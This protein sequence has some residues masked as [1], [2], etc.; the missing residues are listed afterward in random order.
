MPLTG[1][2]YLHD[3]GSLIY[4]RYL[5]DGQVAD[6]RESD[7]VRAFWPCDPSDRAGAW[8][9]LVEASAAGAD[10]AR[11][12][13]LARTWECGDEDAKV[14]AQRVGARVF[15]NGA[16]GWHATLDG[17]SE[18]DEPQ[19]RGASALLALADLA[20]ALGYRPSKMWGNTF[21]DL[22]KSHRARAFAVATEGA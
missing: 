2:Y 1:Y 19:G 8:R 18:A 14:Y 12:A 21:A 6:F 20:K 16:E 9:I 15:P 7:L 3:N 17:L 10:P 4:K 22:L 5:D 11:I 13:E